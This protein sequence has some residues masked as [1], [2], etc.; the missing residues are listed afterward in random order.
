M[1]LYDFL[2]GMWFITLEGEKGPTFGLIKERTGSKEFFTQLFDIETDKPIT[3]Q[4][5][6]F[7]AY[8][9]EHF[10]FDT[11][12]EMKEFVSKMRELAKAPGWIK[13]GGPLS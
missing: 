13:T 1:A 9:K 8:G 3:K 5:R 11:Y 7:D 6:I 2:K 4:L 12:D 10:F